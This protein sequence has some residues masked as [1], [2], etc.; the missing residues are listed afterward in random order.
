MHKVAQARLPHQARSN[1][2]TWFG[3]PHLE[4]VRRPSP[5]ELA[6]HPARPGFGPIDGKR[7]AIDQDLGQTPTSRPEC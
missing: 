5:G 4:K 6:Q 3:I 2:P 1:S 7:E